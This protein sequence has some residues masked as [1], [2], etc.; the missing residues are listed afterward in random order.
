MC[1]EGVLHPVDEPRE[2]NTYSRVASGGGRPR[3]EE[4]GQKSEKFGKLSGYRGK[5]QK[6]KAKIW[7]GYFPLLFTTGTASV[8]A[9]RVPFFNS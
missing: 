1:S 2:P 6:E 5:N 3:G 7:E 8:T 4:S 9:E